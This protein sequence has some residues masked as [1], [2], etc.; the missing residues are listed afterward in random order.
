RPMRRVADPLKQMGANIS[1]EEGG[2]APIRSAPARLQPID[3]NMPVASAQVKSCLLPASLSVQGVTRITEPAPCRDHTERML[4]GFGYPLQVDGNA[5]SI[6]G[7]GRLQA[8]HIDVPADISSAA[9]FLVGASICPGADLTLKHVGI[10][11]TRTGVINILR[12]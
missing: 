4:R 12:A 1:L 7:G 9:F 6:T 11:P 5:V 2:R 8:G 3:F 10:N